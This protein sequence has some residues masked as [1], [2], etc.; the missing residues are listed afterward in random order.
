MAEENTK[1]IENTKNIAANFILFRLP[2]SKYNFSLRVDEVCILLELSLV[3]YYV[4]GKLGI[5]G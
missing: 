3:L 4:L 5:L 1:M 2:M